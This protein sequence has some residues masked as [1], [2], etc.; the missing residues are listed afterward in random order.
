MNEERNQEESMQMLKRI[1]KI[2]HIG[3]LCQLKGLLLII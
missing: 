3:S 1:N 2:I